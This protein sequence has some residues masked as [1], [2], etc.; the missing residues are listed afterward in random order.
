MPL[1]RMSTLRGFGNL[2]ARGAFRRFEL[3]LALADGHGRLAL[4]VTQ[5]VELRAARE[6]RGLHVD[7][8]DT[9]GVDREYALDALAVRDAADGE[10][11]IQQRTLAAD[12]DAR[13]DL[14]TLLVAFDDAGVDAHG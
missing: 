9:R 14:D 4:E 7:L 6:A 12:D 11:L 2:R 5:V 1:R 3:H 10:G 13:K 8:R